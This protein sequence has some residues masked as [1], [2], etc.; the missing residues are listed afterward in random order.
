MPIG[1][2]IGVGVS[3]LGGALIQSSAANRAARVQQR[4]AAQAREDS[5]PFMIPGQGAMGSLAQLYGINP[6]T[7]EY[8]PDA[9]FNEASLAAFRRSPDYQFALREGMG[10]L[11]NSAAARGML[12]SGNTLRAIT[13]YGQGLA[14]QTFGNYRGSLAQLASIGAGAAGQAGQAALAGG[15]AAASGIVGQANAFTGALGT[16][17]NYAMMQH[18]Q[19]QQQ[20]FLQNLLRPSSYTAQQP[21]APATAGSPGFAP[22]PYPGG[23]GG[24]PP[25]FF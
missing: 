13:D 18:Q 4:A 3:S 20:N 14:T 21:F 11:E 22:G 17:G 7:G 5:L 2:A 10:A 25:G 8:S 16:L 19:T 1:T 9:A 6:Q 15:Q 12:R 23:P 24:F